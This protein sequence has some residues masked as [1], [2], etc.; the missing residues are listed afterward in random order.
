[1]KWLLA[2]NAGHSIIVYG[3]DVS[4]AFDRVGADRLAN[5]LTAKGVNERIVKLLVS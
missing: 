5:K 3:S 2:F 1:M 4:G